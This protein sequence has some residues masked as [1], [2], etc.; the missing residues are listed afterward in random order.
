MEM[1][2]IVMRLNGEVQ[3]V[4]ETRSD[5]ARLENLKKLCDLI[6]RLMVEIRQ[7]SHCAERH[8]ASMAAAGKSA[9]NFIRSI[10][11]GDF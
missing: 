6:E 3:P 9:K 4:G 10:E 2:D 7:V 11:Q 5:L 8:E 1:F